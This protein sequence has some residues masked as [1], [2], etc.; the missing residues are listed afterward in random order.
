MASS[1]TRWGLGWIWKN[2]FVER[3]IKN[4]NKLYREVVESP[5]LEGFKP[6]VDVAPGYTVS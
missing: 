6:H 3:V 1:C 4:W 2:F 5:V